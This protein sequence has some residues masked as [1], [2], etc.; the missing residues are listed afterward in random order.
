MLDQRSSGLAGRWL[1]R[2]PWFLLP[3]LLLVAGLLLATSGDPEPPVSADWL[4]RTVASFPLCG[5]EAAL[6][7]A[8]DLGGDAAMDNAAMVAEAHDGHSHICP[9]HPEVQGAAGERCPICGM[10]LVPRPMAGMNMHAMTATDE[11]MAAT[12][13]ALAPA[14]I[15][16]LGVRSAPVERT[17]LHRHIPAPGTVAYDEERVIQL[18]PRSAGWIEELFVFAEGEKV[19]RGDDLAYFFSPA[20][21]WAQIDYL[22]ALEDDELSSFLPSMDDDRMAAF[23]SSYQSSRDNGARLRGTQDI[24]RYLGVPEMYRRRLEQSYDLQAI[25]PIKAP[26]SGVLTRLRAREGMYAEPG[27]TLFTLV[28]LRKVWVMVDVHEHQVAGLH[29]GAMAEIGT[30]AYPGR[31]WRGKVAFVYPEVH[32]V[33][34]TVRARLSFDNPDEVLLPNMFVEAMIHASPREDVLAIPHQALIAD[35]QGYRVIR[36]LGE[37]RFQP[38]RVST[39]LRAGEQVEI[40]DGLAAS[41]RVVVSGQFLIDSESSLQASFQRMTE[42]DHGSGTAHSMVH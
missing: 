25:I 26:H 39:G 32:P 3:G 42:A 14:A 20:A 40:L 11:P 4:T 27:D 38:V 30:P 34:R 24:L 33:T 13:V 17:T 21:L 28:D 41:D 22:S 6:A 19:E 15:R 35:G 9:M 12:T 10:D 31:R 29:D 18:H 1:R 16:H 36:D 8:S 7:V 5:D 23:I 2:L 37:G